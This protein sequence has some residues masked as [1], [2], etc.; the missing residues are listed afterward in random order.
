MEAKHDDISEGILCE[1]PDYRSCGG[2]HTL[3]FFVLR[4]PIREKATAPIIVISMSI[5]SWLYWLLL[6]LVLAGLWWPLR[7]WLF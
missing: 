5:Q 6:A 7:R 3:I 2:I 4:F 1:L